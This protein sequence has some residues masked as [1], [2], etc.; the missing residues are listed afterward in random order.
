[1]ALANYFLAA[2][3]AFLAG[4]LAAAFG[5]GAAFVTTGAAAVFRAVRCSRNAAISALILSLR[6]VSFAM[7]AV[8]LA[9]ALAVFE[10]TGAFLAAAF[11]AGFAVAAGFT[12]LAGAA[13]FLGAGA[14]VASFFF[15]VAMM[16]ILS[17]LIFP[18]QGSIR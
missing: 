12:A 4:A 8:I 16:M 18:H 2:G 9:N 1:M 10:T 5:A 17:V 11:A 15:A 6:S 14:L 3:L 13:V 7:L